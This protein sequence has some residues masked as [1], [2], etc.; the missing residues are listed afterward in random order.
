MDVPDTKP[1][2]KKVRRS[3]DSVAHP[4][5]DV[6]DNDISPFSVESRLEF[7]FMNPKHQIIGKSKSCSKALRE[8]MISTLKTNFFQSKS[9]STKQVR[10]R[11][12]V[13]RDVAK[14]TIINTAPPILIIQFE[15]AMHDP[16]GK[17][18]TRPFKGRVKFGETLDL[19]PYMN[20]GCNDDTCIYWLIGL[21]EKII[22]KKTDHAVAYVRGSTSNDRFAWYHVSDEEVYQV[23]MEGVLG[24]K[25]SKYFSTRCRPG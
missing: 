4:D 24:C 25:K 6:E 21:V 17:S 15:K 5:D 10:N 11:F 19:K 14:I 3:S 22:G 12:N 1:Q 20:P 16:Q 13:K 23:P 18:Y 9:L 2:S 8:G 7:V